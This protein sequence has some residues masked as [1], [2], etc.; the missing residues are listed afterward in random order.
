MSPRFICILAPRVATA[1]GDDPVARC[2]L[3]QRSP[4]A[5]V[6]RNA[7]ALFAG[8]YRGDRNIP[9]H[10]EPARGSRLPLTNRGPGTARF[11]P[12]RPGIRL[13]QQIALIASLISRDSRMQIGQVSV[14]D[15]G[16]LIG[17]GF[18]CRTTILGDVHLLFS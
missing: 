14:I 2:A 17:P 18:V 3:L 10:N 13:L 4:G 8:W 7:S 11:R 6:A 16:T 9:R 1:S 15:L 12:I 5:T